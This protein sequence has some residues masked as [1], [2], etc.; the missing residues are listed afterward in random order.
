[1]FIDIVGYTLAA[2]GR[3]PDESFQFLKD[4]LGFIGKIVHQYGG[5]IDKSLGDGCLCFFGYDISGKEVVGHE[6]TAVACALEIQRKMVD[7]INSVSAE[8]KDIFPLRIGVN[9]ASVCIGNMGDEH[10]VDFTLHGDGVSMAKRF[11]SACEPF[12]VTIGQS[13]YQALDESMRSSEKFYQRLIPIKNASNLTES[14][15]CNPFEKAA[16]A[17]DKARTK[18]WHR[19]GVQRLEQRFSPNKSLFTFNL[20]MVRCSCRIFR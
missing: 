20:F 14:Y 4:T 18:Y 12:K 2:R 9:S 15:E 13:T 19:I 1:M 17:I 11:E 10:R 8:T 5:I 7:Y 6:T 3:K 16:D